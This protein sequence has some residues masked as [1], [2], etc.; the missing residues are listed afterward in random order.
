M[1]AMGLPANIQRPKPNLR[2]KLAFGPLGYGLNSSTRPRVLGRGACE[3]F[4]HTLSLSAFGGIAFQEAVRPEQVGILAIYLA[5][6][7]HGPEV[8][9]DGCAAVSFPLPEGLT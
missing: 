6:Q 2:V 8:H 4:D 3:E 7:Y 5:I 9:P 1:K